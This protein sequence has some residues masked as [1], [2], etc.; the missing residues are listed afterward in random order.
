MKLF[1]QVHHVMLHAADPLEAETALLHFTAGLFTYFGSALT[2]TPTLPEP[3]AIKIARDFI[4]DHYDEKLTLE[5]IASC[6]SMN[7]FTLIR[8][9]KKYT[10]LTP[11]QYL[12]AQR[13]SRAKQLL[14]S[15][16]GP[17]E[18]STMVG[19]YDQSHFY[20]KFKLFSQGHTPGEF[21]ASL[22][23]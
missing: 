7:P 13:V 9:F 3:V 23:G 10:G 12:T 2:A 8:V 20:K 21:I 14:A 4:C 1:E 5:Q 18:V 11:F 17:A 16:F 19:F 22:R 15:G 6:A